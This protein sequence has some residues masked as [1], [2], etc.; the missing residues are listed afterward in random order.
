[1][2]PDRSAFLNATSRAL[3]FAKEAEQS[4]LVMVLDIKKF[5]RF[6]HAFGYE[7]ADQI[8]EEVGRRLSDSVN[9]K[10]KVTRIGDNRFGVLIPNIENAQLLPVMVTNIVEQ[11]GQPYQ[12]QLKPVKIESRVGACLYPE[13]ANNLDQVISEAE[14]ALFVAKAED[15]VF[16]FPQAS[17]DDS[18]TQDW[19]VEAQLLNAI[20]E[21]E[22]RL[23]Y[24]PKIDL[25]SFAPSG[26]EALLRWTNSELGFVSPEKFV[27]VA[28]ESG[29]IRE[30][31][32]WVIKNALR[33]T[34]M[35][36]KALA[37]GVAVNVSAKCI[38]DDEISRLITSHLNIWG[39][40]P[41]QL[42]VE[43]T[44]TAL[45]E[46][47]ETA[48]AYIKAL[49]AAGVKVSIDDFGTGFSSLSKFKSM[50]A[51]ELKID[52]SFVSGML[53][54]EDDRNIVMAVIDLA[55]RFDLKVV[56]EGVEDKDTL[57][58]LVKMGC[59]YAQGYHFA[60]PLVFEEYSDWVANYRMADYF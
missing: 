4:C 11:V 59:D 14:K 54:R 10:S 39:V 51:D 58:A 7:A 52:K 9:D 48:I 47:P 30:I 27:P 26:S 22:F 13:H 28:E 17:N 32:D 60:K 44:E 37:A 16:H 38:A 43:I 21:D 31:T 5:H 45:I 36:P 55:K 2:Q 56:A 41:A 57:Q 53:E 3:H 1:M 49:R 6:N 46:D 42:S 20:D 33:E 34:S 24:Q 35:L 15:S 8:L 25:H 18:I 23:F 29:A 19:D 40:K 50:P 12:L